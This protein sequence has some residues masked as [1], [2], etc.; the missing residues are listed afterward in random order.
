MQSL[1]SLTGSTS[2]WS[3]KT[4]S[5]AQSSRHFTISASHH[6]SSTA[7]SSHSILS[8]A[9]TTA[10]KSNPGAGSKSKVAAPKRQL[11]SRDWTLE[12]DALLLDLLRQSVSWREAGRRMGRS[13]ATCTKHYQNTL[14]PA[15]NPGGPWL[16]SGRASAADATLLR[17][18]LVEEKPWHEIA[19]ELGVAVNIC[20]ARFR[21]VEDS[22][23]TIFQE[24]K[25]KAS[26]IQE[27]Y[28]RWL[29]K[30]ITKTK[31][32]VLKG[33][34]AEAVWT[35]MMDETLINLKETTH[36]SWRQIQDTLGMDYV[37]CRVR[38]H[39]LSP[40]PP[41]V[42]SPA[43][44][45]AP[46]SM[47]KIRKA[48][49]PRLPKIGDVPPPQL[50]E[51]QGV[52]RPQLL[53]FHSRIKPGLVSRTNFWT[54]EKDELLLK[55][56][57]VNADVTWQ[58]IADHIG[59][60]REYCH[61]RYKTVLE[62][63]IKNLWTDGNTEQL[64][65]LVA[66]KKPWKDIST[67]LGI[68]PYA[69]RRQWIV[70]K[71]AMDAAAKEA[72][73]KVAAAAKKASAAQAQYED[74]QGIK[75]HAALQMRIERNYD[76]YDWSQL[77][78]HFSRKGYVSEEA[79]QQRWQW[80]EQHHPWTPREETS[81]IQ[82][83]LRYGVSQWDRIANN[84]N[85]MELRKGRGQ[86]ISAIECKIYWKNLDMPVHRAVDM[87][88][89]RSSAQ[90]VFWSAWLQQTQEH[91]DEG[92]DHIWDNISKNPNIPGDSNQ[93]RLYF[94]TATEPLKTLN[95]ETLEDFARQQ[96]S[97]NQHVETASGMRR[98]HWHKRRSVALQQLIRLQT[99]SRLRKGL[100]QVKWNS[101]TRQLNR[102]AAAYRA[103]NEV[104]KQEQSSEE[105]VRNIKDIQAIG[106]QQCKMHWFRLRAAAGPHWSQDELKL[107]ERGI[108]ELGHS[109]MDIQQKYLSWRDVSMLKSQWYLISDHA[110]RITVDEYV[111]LL[112]AVEE[113][114][115][116][117]DS[118][119]KVDWGKVASRM[120]G[121]AS[122]P[123]RRVY[124]QSYQY[125]LRHT[126]FSP[127]EDAW[128]LQNINIDEPQDW[129][130][131]AKRFD[132]RGKDGW[133]YRLRWCQLI[134]R[135]YA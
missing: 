67:A 108:R 58:T 38:Y 25:L 48:P 12:S 37:S 99:K 43:R 30:H 35:K 106:I 7:A 42:A 75:H 6:Q 73:A 117:D 46:S 40:P 120:P 82:Q 11:Y 24:Q 2:S 13:A 78:G 15:L 124:E 87:N 64:K 53:D 126:E 61:K 41:P 19:E 113:L 93:C 63:L 80:L 134:D 77:L 32:Q 91:T 105:T 115:V 39:Q 114:Q 94:E 128:L 111:T 56:K 76:S 10:T 57:E 86:D 131:I 5:A 96:I 135:E 90:R 110:A 109:W 97:R 79:R 26:E 85:R 112:L 127:E 116:G 44:P 31:T 68:H 66:E 8:A 98:H 36:K 29:L 132:Q 52:P 130:D 23:Q 50:L 55:L 21:G 81:L 59:V 60:T 88:E 28:D 34:T 65:Q 17:R 49:R 62:P 100:K 83:V 16:E 45:A 107:L 122:N 72:A 3:W 133:Q 118:D 1:L 33:E 102:F 101:I 129:N 89:W 104:F 119:W 47:Q 51:I 22:F 4:V 123:C 69:C 74:I 27:W 125:M 70:V 9:T 121:W 20:H 14:L 92:D 84:L 71:V 18:R 54:A 95:D 103:G